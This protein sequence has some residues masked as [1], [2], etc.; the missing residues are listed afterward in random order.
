VGRA[1]RDRARTIRWGV[2]AVTR[3]E[4]VL[5]GVLLG[6][7]AGSL[8]LPGP[9][10]AARLRRLAGTGG[11]TTGAAP[12]GSGGADSSP[13]G[14]ASAGRGRVRWWAAALAGPATCVV[15]GGLLGVVGGLLAAVAVERVLGR[16][17]P[18]AL[19][20]EREAAS[21]QLPFA[22]DLLAAAL[23]GGA[24]PEAA[25]RC[26]AAGVG[27]PLGAR[28]Q[29]VATAYTVD[30]EPADLWCSLAGL[31]AAPPI[32]R[33]ALRSRRSGASLAVAL[34]RA[35]AEARAAAGAA[36]E[37]SARRAGVLVVLPVGMCFLP[38]FV[39]LG[40]VPVAAGMVTGAL[41]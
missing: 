35:A 33:A 11:P 13:V 12:G 14:D 27:G 4:V 7:A 8:A 21:A 36:A 9:G 1:H 5:A 10:P 38:A 30:A 25:L 32:V 19:L 24:T 28:L 37:V 6:A 15:L 20:R 41:T 29:R 16:M 31:P 39:L 22:A 3:P 2:T 23:L 26:V 34:R 18:R 40:V 17:E